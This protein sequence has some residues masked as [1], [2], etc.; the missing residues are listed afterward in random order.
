MLPVLFEKKITPRCGYCARSDV[1][2][3]GMVLCLKKGV[4]P[5]NF[6]CR[7]FRYDPFKRVPPRPG[8]PPSDSFRDEDFSL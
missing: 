1:L 5:E 8:P 4:V 3:E 6:Q 7:A 2:E